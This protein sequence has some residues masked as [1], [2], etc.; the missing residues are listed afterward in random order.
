MRLCFALL[1]L[2][3]SLSPAFAETESGIDPQIL[4][5]WAYR[6]LTYAEDTLVIR[7]DG[8]L[9]Q[10]GILS[11]KLFVD[12]EASYDLDQT[13][14]PKR[15]VMTV[16]KVNP[17]TVVKSKVGEKHLC[18]YRVNP[19]GKLMNLD[20]ADEG[21]PYPESFQEAYAYAREGDE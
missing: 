21:K 10:K 19:G 1:A 13:T 12:V 20:C 8:T 6:F 5:R 15:L 7:R 17:D 14:T 11:D 9:A 2:L 3:L 18:I 4:G 16:T